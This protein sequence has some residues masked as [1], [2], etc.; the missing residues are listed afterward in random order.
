MGLSILPSIKGRVCCDE[1]RMLANGDRKGDSA[2]F[3]EEGTYEGKAS[4]GWTVF[5]I[6]SHAFGVV[7]AVPSKSTESIMLL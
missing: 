6:T 1:C 4:A 2:T 7:G 5:I 3:T